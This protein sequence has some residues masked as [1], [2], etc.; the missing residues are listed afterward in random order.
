[1]A[2]N[3]VK[4]IQ[5]NIDFKVVFNNLPL[6][7]I[8][9]DKQ[10][11]IIDANAPG[12]RAFGYP[13]KEMIGKNICHLFQF[14]SPGLSITAEPEQTEI[15]V[16]G[17]G[18]RKDGTAFPVEYRRSNYWDGNTSLTI[19][20][21][22]SISESRTGVKD[23]NELIFS[24]QSSTFGNEKK[25]AEHQTRISDLPSENS[26]AFQKI[27]LDY[28]GA[29]II[30]TDVKGIITF[31]NREASRNTGY[32][33]EEVIN[34]ETPLIFHDKI[35]IVR[36]QNE[37]SEIS[38]KI[39]DGGFSALVE[40][41]KAGIHEEEEFTFI[42]KDKTT[43]PVSL[44][45][46]A[47]RDSG[48]K[49][50]GFIGVAV[51]ISERRKAEGEL[52]KIKKLFLQLLKNYP[53]GLISIINHQYR[54][55]FTGGE[56][57]DR[58]KA[59]QDRLIGAELFPNFSETL[60]DVV[61]QKLEQVFTS[62]NSLSDFE[63]PE[64]VAGDLYMM[65]AFPLVEEDGTINKVGLII[66]NISELKKTEKE[67][68][69]A[70]RKERELGEMKSRFVSMASHEFRT[71]LST[72]LSSAYLIEKYSRSDDQPKREKHLQ[73]IISSVNILTDILNDFLSLGKIEEGKIQVKN[74]TFNLREMI[75]E[76]IREI[77][78]TLKTGQKIEYR[79]QG[80]PEIFSDASLLKF[81]L[82][83]LISNA[84]KFSPEG[85]NIEIETIH[86]D[87]NMKLSV[88]DYGIGIPKQ[89]QEH[90]MTRF[91]RG[92]NATTIQGTGL[93]LNIV[94]R[95]VEMLEGDISFESELKKGTKFLITLNSKSG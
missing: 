18:I 2:S 73:R 52:R 28:A 85:A 3:D 89:D 68:R 30:V 87:G 76:L 82:L 22:S 17:R 62:G 8:V 67:L 56:L 63:L 83:N 31:F 11:N 27:I 66:R 50:T 47:L 7:I 64:A 25:A 75:C 20:L 24:S 54:F 91:F 88:K 4:I 72:V 92:T 65:D 12:I 44:T 10:G 36:K 53:D 38:G 79:H 93:G 40:N 42:R 84:R 5:R 51:D 49:I 39:T 80:H 69:K 55:L 13:G 26:R 70:L 95:Y 14:N 78:P 77:E 71:P 45:I 21:V 9:S 37:F 58:L 29:M 1:M 57:H 41:A 48:E 94:A 43:F 19:Y 33:D 34:K 90:L 86:K 74:F 60:R 23:D 32:S 6:G 59:D 15:V 46:T 61:R 35:E 16:P 81:I